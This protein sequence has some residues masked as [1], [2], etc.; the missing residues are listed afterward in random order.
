MSFAISAAMGSPG[1]YLGSINTGIKMADVR[2]PNKDV[3]SRILF[4]TSYNQIVNDLDR[5]H[6]RYNRMLADNGRTARP[7][8]E[9]T[10]RGVSSE[11]EEAANE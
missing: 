10:L 9:T 2:N 7:E 11:Y 5:E 1:V 3:L 8:Y 4:E 6:G